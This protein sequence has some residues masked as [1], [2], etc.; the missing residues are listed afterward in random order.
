MY[1]INVLCCVGRYLSQYDWHSQL[2]SHH[3]ALGT[4]SQKIKMLYHIMI[5][6]YIMGTIKMMFLKDM[7]M[8]PRIYWEENPCQNSWESLP[9]S[10]RN[11]C[12]NSSGMFPSA[13]FAICCSWRV[14]VL[15]PTRLWQQ[16]LCS[17]RKVFLFVEAG[18]C[19]LVLWECHHDCGLYICIHMM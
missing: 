3:Y 17:S 9:A 12:L 6:H 11:H 15:I 5:I 14:W 8:H 1:A 10:G 19:S 16:F 18:T 13:Y 4:F 7:G 2:H